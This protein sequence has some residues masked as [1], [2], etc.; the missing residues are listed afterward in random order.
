MSR[1]R[2][3]MSHPDISTFHLKKGQWLNSEVF[4]KG[5]SHL[6]GAKSCGKRKNA[7]NNLS[8]NAHKFKYCLF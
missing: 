3:E 5:T 8:S 7:K 6:H 4:P 2:Y 1:F